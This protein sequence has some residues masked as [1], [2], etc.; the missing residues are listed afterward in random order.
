MEE[1][2]TRY[3]VPPKYLVQILIELKSKQ[4]VGSQRGK[5]GGYFLARPPSEIT[6]GDILRA[7]H[8]EVFDSPA[9][10]DS[11]CPAELRGA[12]K[13]LQAALDHAADRITFQRLLDESPDKQT[14]YYI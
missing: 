3:G 12:W 7:V 5:E 2:A 1:L 10:A 6:M 13:Q 4:I 9:L 14:T 11:Q 8:G